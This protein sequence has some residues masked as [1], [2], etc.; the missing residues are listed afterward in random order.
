MTL[1]ILFTLAYTVQDV[2]KIFNMK[3]L[4]LA[5]LIALGL[6][7]SAQFIPTQNWWL[8][9]IGMVGIVVIKKLAPF[10]IV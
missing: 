4:I 2:K 1:P 7:L 10:D 8:L 3:K 9:M 5:T 6:I